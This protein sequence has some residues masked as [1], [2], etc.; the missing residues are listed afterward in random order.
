MSDAQVLSFQDSDLL[1]PNSVCEVSEGPPED[2]AKSLTLSQ[3]L[4]LTFENLDEGGV[5]TFERVCQGNDGDNN[6]VE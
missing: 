6:P 5:G 2:S 3:S 1:S 4:S